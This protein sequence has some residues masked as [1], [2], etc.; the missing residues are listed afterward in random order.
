MVTLLTISNVLQIPQ[1]RPLPMNHA[2]SIPTT[3]TEQNAAP[4]VGTSNLQDSPHY[5][6]NKIS[7]MPKIVWGIIDH[8]K[9]VA[10]GGLVVVFC[11][12]IGLVVTI[13]QYRLS[14]RSDARSAQDSIESGK[15]TD[16]LI[17]N[18]NEISKALQESVAQ[19]KMAFEESIAQSRKALDASIEA[20]K[21][22]QRAW[23]TIREANIIELTPG[24][25]PRV[26][27]DI[28]NTG[29]TP[30]TLRSIFKLVVT[31]ALDDIELS[32]KWLDGPGSDGPSSVVGPGIS[33][34]CPCIGTSAVSEEEI[35]RIKSGSI[36][37]FV[38][39]VLVYKDAFGKEHKTRYCLFTNAGDRGRL[40]G[41][42]KGNTIE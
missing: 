22:E 40:A 15:Q 17:A 10:F 31:P 7:Q 8:P 21:Q 32:Q 12:V 20:S 42:P 9:L 1:S 36:H 25:P 33:V 23:I 3:E 19:S 4:K 38:F 5:P 14:V 27:I 11:S 35:A 28:L 39:G 37:I 24:K 2:S 18:S 16:R 41:Y 30:C 34:A 26:E 13:I 6:D 29:K